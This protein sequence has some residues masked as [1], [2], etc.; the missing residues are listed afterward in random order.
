[1]LK[2][3]KNYTY[4]DNDTEVYKKLVKQTNVMSHA[5]NQKRSSRPKQTYK[6]NKIFKL[7]EKEGDGIKFLP[8]N[9]I[10]LQQQLSYFLAEYRVGNR[11]ATRNQIGAIA[12]NLLKGKHITKS[13]YRKINNYISP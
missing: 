2:V 1:M 10:S 6:W 12:D 13:E 4:T 5:N 8:S 11:S 9:I 7:V 3:P